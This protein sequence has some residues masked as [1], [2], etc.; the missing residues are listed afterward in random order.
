MYANIYIHFG[1]FKRHFSQNF[2]SLLSL[3]IL[4]SLP[5]KELVFK[6]LHQNDLLKK[7]IKMYRSQFHKDL[8]EILKDYIKFLTL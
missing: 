2:I 6:G 5:V 4:T 1:L 3:A 8:K 7:N